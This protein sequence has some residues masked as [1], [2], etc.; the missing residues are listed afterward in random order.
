MK[1]YKL[2]YFNEHLF[3]FFRS[4]PDTGSVILIRDLC[5]AE[6]KHQSALLETRD[7]FSSVITAL[8]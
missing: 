7:R 1:A 8:S 4:I 5:K 2:Y 3:E 6:I